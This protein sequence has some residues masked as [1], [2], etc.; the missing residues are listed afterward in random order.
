MT[1]TKYKLRKMGWRYATFEGPKGGDPT[2]IVDLVALKVSRNKKSHLRDTVKVF[3]FQ[4][5]ANS[6]V[7]QKEKER[8]RMAVRRAKIWWAYAEKPKNKMPN[9]T[10]QVPLD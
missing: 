4:V 10:S 1:F 6:K 7:T 3:F 9:I 5:K 2:G 8:L